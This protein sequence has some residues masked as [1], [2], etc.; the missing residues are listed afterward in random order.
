M[1]YSLHLLNILYIIKYN[2]TY[3]TYNIILLTVMIGTYPTWYYHYLS[4]E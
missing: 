4:F 2:I 1:Y 3:Y